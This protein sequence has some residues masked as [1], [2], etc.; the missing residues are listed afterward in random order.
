MHDGIYLLPWFYQI[1]LIKMVA[2]QFS[3]IVATRDFVVYVFC[4]M[5]PSHEL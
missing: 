5:N 1:G 3:Q 4:C 2:Y